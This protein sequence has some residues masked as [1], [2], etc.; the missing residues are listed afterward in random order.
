V[1]EDWETGGGLSF[2]EWLRRRRGGLGLTQ[3]ELAHQLGCAP[4]TLRKIEAEERRP[5]VLM[6]Q[7]MAAFLHIPPDLHDAF[8][9]FARGEL[10]AGS[11]IVA[12]TSTS[13]STANSAPELAPAEHLP[14]P[15]YDIVGRDVLLSSASHDFI[16]SHV[17]LL[18]LVGPPG[19]GKTRLAL[20]L[21][22]RL[23]SRFTHGAL[24]IELAPVVKPQQVANTIAQ[25]LGLIEDKHGS[26]QQAILAHLRK[27]QCLL[28]LDNF[29]HV[30]DTAPFVAELVAECAG[31]R[32]LVT[33]RERLRVRAEHL[34]PVPALDLPSTRAVEEVQRAAATQL[35]IT[36]ATAVNPQFALDTSN[37]GDVA[38]LCER[39]DGLPLAIE[40]IAARAET[41]SPGQ[42]VRQIEHRLPALVDGP[43]DLPARQQTLRNAIRWSFS[44]LT[45]Q[46]Q[47]VFAHTGVFVG[48]F[49]AGA[50]QAVLGTDASCESTLDALQQASL[51]QR[52]EA[53][54]NAPRYSLLET[55]REFALEELASRGEDEVACERH[56]TFFAGMAMSTRGK[57]GNEQQAE[58]Y[59]Q[60]AANL[61][62]IRTSLRWA[63][64]HNRHGML[65]EASARLYH[66]WWQRGLGNEGLRWLELGLPHRE[67]VSM[68]VQAEA[69]V[70]AGILAFQ[71]DD[72]AR[73]EPYLLDA[74]QAAR[75]AGHMGLVRGT[76]ANLGILMMMQGAFDRV[77]PYLTE[78]IAV[79][80]AINQKEYARFTLTVLG[81]LRYR[82]GEYASA[83]DAYAQALIINQACNDEEGIADSMWGLARALRGLGDYHEA[84]QHCDEA[85]PI[86][87]KLDHEQGEGWVLNVRADIARDT[88][89]FA[90]ALTLYRLALD[91]RL[92]YNDKQGCTRVLDETAQAASKDLRRQLAVRLMGAADRARVHLGGQMTPYEQLQRDNAL[93]L[94]QVALSSH[95][96]AE[97]WTQGQDMSLQQAVALVA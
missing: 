94:C 64:K 3:A 91:I 30:L 15:P 66:F 35:F 20:E 18:T 95:E 87:R 21:A 90:N 40:L 69:L 8:M 88:G 44:R 10:R 31:V 72:Y 6:A 11:K 83:K 63:E 81:D 33:S 28:V 89:N 73:A 24:F 5:S 53:Y 57:L 2:G 7:R 67:Q 74:L 17:R 82:Q 16:N 47:H 32:C 97:A 34:L 19:V 39:L 14:Q 23:R 93:A 4:I 36:R 41:D 49:T 96:Y 85:Q 45:P 77:E 92:K 1:T 58:W 84:T 60:L 26:P 38:E 51:V 54:G 62:N 48:G 65:L 78:A 27:R 68:A 46:Q 12:S 43:R 56:A 75:N 86:Y 52:H 25:G 13:T 50:M 80:R 79:T 70:N 76:L 42:I 55:I 9:R 59:R 22:H 37:A 61:D 71:K 29:E